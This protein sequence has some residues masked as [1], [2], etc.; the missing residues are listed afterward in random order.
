MLAISSQSFALSRQNT[1][2]T[3]ADH[4]IDLPQP[5]AI[6]G[7]MVTTWPPRWGFSN[8]PFRLVLPLSL[9]WIAILVLG[10]AYLFLK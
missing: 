2:A 3:P 8:A 10:C 9:I 4:S 1:P 7:T 6:A 5:E